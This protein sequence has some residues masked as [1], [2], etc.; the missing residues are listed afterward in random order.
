MFKGKV[1][2]VYFKRLK[3][4]QDLI[5]ELK[6]TAES[7]GIKSGVI[8]AIGALKKVRVGVYGKEGRYNIVEKE[9]FHELLSCM[10]N[11][12]VDEKGEVFIHAH[13]LAVDREENFIGGHLLEGSIVDVTV[14]V[15]IIETDAKLVRAKDEETGLYLLKIE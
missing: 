13:I 8:T 5:K 15:A 3:L 9:G 10:G 1:L 2:N 11:I 6:K 12:S 4:N 7:L 14:E